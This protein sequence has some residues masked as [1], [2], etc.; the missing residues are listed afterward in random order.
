MHTAQLVTHP[1]QE[2]YTTAAPFGGFIQGYHTFGGK[3]LGQGR[4]F[5]LS[6]TIKFY[7]AKYFNPINQSYLWEVPIQFIVDGASIPKVA[8]SIVGGPFSGA[9]RLSSGIHDRLCSNLGYKGRVEYQLVHALFA[10]MITAEGMTGRK[11]WYMAKAV[12]VGGPR[13]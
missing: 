13:W 4:D 3:F 12:K 10:E 11:Q 5:Q 8:W 6:D 2:S 9:Y 1:I 7:S